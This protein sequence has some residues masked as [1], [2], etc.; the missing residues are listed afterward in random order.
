MVPV[1][2]S[3][4]T[5]KG[6]FHRPRGVR[7]AVLLLLVFLLSG[8]PITNQSVQISEEGDTEWI[9]FNLPDDSIRNLVGELDEALSLEERPLLAY[10]RLGIHDASGVLFETEIPEE[11]LTIRPDLA[12]V[13]VSTEYRFSEVRASI[14]DQIGVEVREFIAPSGLLVQG[15][16]SG[17][18]MMK[19]IEGVAA[20]QPVPIAMIVDFSVMD[21][22]GEV[23]VRIES[24]RGE[25]LL[26]GVD[27]AD[28]WGMRLHQEIDIVAKTMLSD[29]SL[30]ETGRYDGITSTSIATIAAEPSVAWI[31]HQPTLTI[32]NEKARSWMN[33]G[34]ME[35]SFTT[36]LDGSGQIIAVADSGLDHD[37]GDFGSR[38]V[39]NVDVIG[40]GS[41]ADAHSGHGTHVACT[42][43]GDGT[44]GI[45]RG[46][47]PEAELYF[48]AMEND[49]NQD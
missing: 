17:L 29:S 24:W 41:T 47:A 40:D 9:R 22:D 37:H 44:R 23:P 7:K 36:D 12:L 33:I 13:L 42:V 28:N 35:T 19:E 25:T 4:A 20:I 5:P 2:K 8:M 32:W 43:L 11:L 18:D 27:I 26:P 34:P 15:T 21:S 10:S 3:M 6:G 30:A 49:I 38:I 46:V 39:G 48:Q 16:Q 45:Y 31:G 14:S 1:K